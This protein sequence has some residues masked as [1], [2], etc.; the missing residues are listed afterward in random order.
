MYG[1][2][3]KVKDGANQFQLVYVYSRYVEYERKG[4]KLTDCLNL[5]NQLRFLLASFSLI[6]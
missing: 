4:S 6:V 3:N 5:S 1:K 2:Q